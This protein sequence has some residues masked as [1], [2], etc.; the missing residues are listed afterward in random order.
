MTSTNPPNTIHIHNE[1]AGNRIGLLN[2]CKVREYE[3]C[4]CCPYKNQTKRDSLLKIY[5]KATK[6]HELR[7]I[8][9]NISLSQQFDQVSWLSTHVVLTP[10]S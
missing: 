4:S 2:Y 7:L 9:F 5:T 3:H 8:W 10:C 1:T 6:K